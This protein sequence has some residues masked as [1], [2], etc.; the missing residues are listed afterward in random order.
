MLQTLNWTKKAFHSKQPKQ[1]TNTRQEG[2]K[3]NKTNRD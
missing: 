2:K 3:K 1:E